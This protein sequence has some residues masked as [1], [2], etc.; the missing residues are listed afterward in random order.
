MFPEFE[1]LR[2]M[3]LCEDKKIAK[4]EKI[5][6]EYN[7]NNITIRKK[8]FL[9]YYSNIITTSKI[10][11]LIIKNM[12]E[13]DKTFLIEYKIILTNHINASNA[14]IRNMIIQNISK[15]YEYCE[16]S[17][18]T[19]SMINILIEFALEHKE[20]ESKEEQ[21]YE[22]SEEESE[23]EEEEEETEEE[24]E[25]EQEESTEEEEEEEEEE[26]EESTEEE[27]EEE[28]EEEEEEAEEETEE[29]ENDNE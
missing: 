28:A 17:K 26:Q 14:H 15:D 19:L 4:I 20:E 1:T 8:M 7:T 29:E 3:E 23:S 12:I 5:V 9:T 16:E 13:L 2:W 27:E 11:K 6:Q 22:E 24:Q 25:E 21:E 18:K 10:I